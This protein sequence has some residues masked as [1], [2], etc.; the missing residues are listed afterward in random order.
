MIV[1]ISTY[2]SYILTSNRGI[3]TYHIRFRYCTV[4]TYNTVPSFRLLQVSLST[5][6]LSVP[7]HD[8]YDNN[9]RS[10]TSHLKTAANSFI[11]WP[12]FSVTSLCRINYLQLL[13]NRQVGR[14]VYLV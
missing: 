3:I 4:C 11:S 5:T 10:T 14:K 9:A 12:L 13:T 2:V 8:P 6:T 1:C 7:P